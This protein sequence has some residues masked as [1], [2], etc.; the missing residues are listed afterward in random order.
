LKNAMQ[1]KGII[2]NMTAKT[3]I[4][5]NALLQNYM[6]ERLLE[7]ISVSEYK[8]KFILKGGMLISAVVG[9]DSRTT[10]DMDATIKGIDFSKES[11]LSILE[12]IIS[13]P[14]QDDVRFNLKGVEEI[15]EESEYGGYRISLDATYETIVVPLKIDISTGDMIT[16]KEVLY[17]FELLFEDRKIEILAYNLETVLAEKFETIISR[18]ILNTRAR[19]FYDVY[20]LTTLQ[21]KNI[22]KTDFK[23]A[24]ASTAAKRESLGK[25]DNSLSIL[26][27]IKEDKALQDIWKAYAKKFEYAGDIPFKDTIAALRKLFKMYSS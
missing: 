22:N 26:E 27:E 5:A 7:R 6:L 15:R 8:W 4:K 25:I 10:M 24:F 2:K 12:Q 23:N 19:D 13:I 3:G 1:L 9:L 18:G 11:L 21:E 16:P 20:I 14:V 17:S